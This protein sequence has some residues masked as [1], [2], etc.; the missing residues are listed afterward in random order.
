MTNSILNSATCNLKTPLMTLKISRTVSKNKIKTLQTLTF[1]TKKEIKNYL[2][3]IQKRKRTLIKTN[4][5][6]ITEATSLKRC[7]TKITTMPNSE[8]SQITTQR[9]T[10][11][12]YLQESRRFWT[13]R[14]SS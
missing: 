11:E 10:V 6:K 13:I 4:S 2:K 14:R 1:K 9:A 12:A 8:N 7:F 3:M 5:W